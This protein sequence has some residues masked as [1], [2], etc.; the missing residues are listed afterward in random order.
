MKK[1]ITMVFAIVLSFSFFGCR[2]GAAIYNV[3][4]HVIAANN[5]KA[6]MEDIEK[7][8][9]RAG[10]GLGWVITKESPGEL[11]A[12]L[13]LRA[14]IAVVSIKYS[15]TQ[16]SINY[17]SS[18]NLEYNASNNTIHTNYNG[19]IKNLN[20]AIQSQLLF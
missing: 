12:T 4:D 17:V 16:Y 9:T 18:T 8:I 13:K 20:Q 14:H 19:W 3:N 6:S 10:V 5:Q 1:I 15:T 7:A 2:G 11:K